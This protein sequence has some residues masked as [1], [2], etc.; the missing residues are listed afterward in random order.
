MSLPRPAD[1]PLAAIS[2][3]CIAVLLFAVMDALVKHAAARYG[4]VQIVFFRSA[5]AFLPVAAYLARTGG[6][7]QLKTHRFG[8]HALRAGIGL[9]AMFCFFYAFGVL[10]LAD[11]VSIGFAAPILLTALAGPLLGERVGWRRWSAVIAGFLGV[12][13]MLRPT[14]E[15][16]F[17]SLIALAGTFGYTLTI[18]AIR[19]LSR[20]ESAGTIVFYFSAL[21]TLGAGL[22]LPFDWR[23]P[24]AAGWGVL[25]AIGL[26]GGFAQIFMTRAFALGPASVVAPFDYVAIL[27]ATLLGWSFWGEVPDEATAAGAAVVVASGL[28]ILR[29]EAIRAAQATRTPEMKV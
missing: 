9:S 6:F 3:M 5:F 21:S 29:R 25:V 8:G 23:T 4:V 10:P 19:Q 24:D 13:I 20:T 27:W 12:L 2:F 17:G 15:I 22:L 7:A 28:Y 26:L 14:G 16:A 11:V 1:R 18:V